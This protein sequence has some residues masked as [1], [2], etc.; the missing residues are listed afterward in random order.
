MQTMKK[1]SLVMLLLTLCSVATAWA[2]FAPEANRR[3]TLKENSTG[4][5]LDIQTLDI[6]EPGHT[7]H[8]ISLND[9]ARAIYFEVGAAGKWR[10]RNADGGYARQA[11]GGRHWNAVI[12]DQPYEWTIVETD[13]LVTIARADG[14]YISMDNP[15]AG[16]PLYCDKSSVLR[17]QLMEYPSVA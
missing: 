3:Y 7:T 8:S 15:T 13:G 10:M 9:N 12:G 2:E 11:D 14:K 16:Q 6:H 17:C 4:L 5:Y 1:K